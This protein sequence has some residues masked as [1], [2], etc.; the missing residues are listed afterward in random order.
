[1]VG[2]EIARF[3]GLPR[4]VEPDGG[5][6]RIADTGDDR[7]NLL[8]YADDGGRALSDGQKRMLRRSPTLR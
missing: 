4:A 1:V 8:H 7:G 3:L 5:R 2:H 6:D